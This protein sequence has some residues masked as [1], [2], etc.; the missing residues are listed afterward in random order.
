MIKNR[1]FIADSL[2]IKKF[3]YLINFKLREEL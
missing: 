3:F 1:A 2:D